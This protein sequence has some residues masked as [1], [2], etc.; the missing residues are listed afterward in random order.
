MKA[1]RGSIRINRPR[2]LAIEGRTMKTDSRTDPGYPEL[3]TTLELIEYLRIPEISTASNYDNVIDNLKRFHG[4]PC[5]H[6]SKKPLFPLEAI[7]HWVQQKLS[8]ER[9]R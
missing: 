2:Y 4:L 6:I 1:S 8:K 9:S 5:I 3:M 7:R